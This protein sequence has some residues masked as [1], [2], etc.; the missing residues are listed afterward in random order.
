MLSGPRLA[1]SALLSAPEKQT[2]LRNRAPEQNAHQS[3]AR[4]P[5]ASTHP[6]G[7][8]QEQGSVAPAVPEDEE[9]PRERPARQGWPS[10]GPRRPQP[11]RLGRDTAAAITAL[12][13]RRVLGARGE[14]C[15]R[16]QTQPGARPP[17]WRRAGEE[18]LACPDDPLNLD[19]GVIQL[20]GKE[21]HGL[22]GVFARVGVDVRPPGR[23][24][25]CREAGNAQGAGEKGSAGLPPARPG[26]RS[27][28][29][30][31]SSSASSVN[32][33]PF[34]KQSKRL[35]FKVSRK[36]LVGLNRPDC[37]APAPQPLGQRRAAPSP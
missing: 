31:I 2:G 24:F 27:R 10:G 34:R 32:F 23:D 13:R 33:P 36:F 20:F 5:A 37:S 30:S 15:G 28:S 9:L 26:K 35:N 17:P 16:A 14:R 1:P 3:R 19:A 7:Q 11:R 4:L 29:L 6:P 12:P 8:E 25:N 22:Q 18:E 21:V